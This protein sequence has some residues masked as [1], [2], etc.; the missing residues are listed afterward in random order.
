MMINQEKWFSTMMTKKT[1]YGELVKDYRLSFFD[2]C[3]NISFDTRW[4][5]I[6]LNESITEILPFDVSKEKIEFGISN[7]V[8]IFSNTLLE[9]V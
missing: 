5:K 9:F 3:R 6:N 7:Y 8:G 1:C 4:V 2:D